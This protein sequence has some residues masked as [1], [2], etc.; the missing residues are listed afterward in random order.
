ML[1]ARSIATLGASTKSGVR[2][3]GLSKLLEDSRAKLSDVSIVMA[4]LW[5]SGLP[6]P[7]LR[8]AGMR[9]ALSCVDGKVYV[10]GEGNRALTQRLVSLLIRMFASLHERCPKERVHKV[11]P[12]VR[13]TA[14]AHIGAS[15]TFCF[16]YDLNI[17]GR[18]SPS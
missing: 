3:L 18:T 16:C 17:F 10:T 1:Y 12:R 9:S 4:T 8:T 14:S 11:P 7:R 13:N 15:T 2:V 6:I 5:V